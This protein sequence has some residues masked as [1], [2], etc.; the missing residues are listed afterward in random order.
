MARRLDEWRERRIARECVFSDDVGSA[1]I[2][3]SS[4][5]RQRIEICDANRSIRL[6]A[7]ELPNSNSL[8][9]AAHDAFAMRVS[10]MSA[11]C[12]RSTVTLSCRM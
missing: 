2:G 9:E 1:T 12:Q 3:I 11:T 7:T 8:R 10:R 5:C 4:V 6:R